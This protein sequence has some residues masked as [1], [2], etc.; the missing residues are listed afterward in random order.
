M[1]DFI[2]ETFKARDGAK[3]FYRKSSED[4][5]NRILVLHGLLEYSV[6]YPP[7]LDHLFPEG[8]VSWVV[9]DLRGH[10]VSEG[11]RNE[12]RPEILSND[13]EDLLAHIGWK[14]GTFSG[15]AHSFGGLLALYI[16]CKKPEFFKSL[17]LSAPFLGMPD[18]KTIFEIWF[19]LLLASLFPNKRYKNPVPAKYLTHNPER[20]ERYKND[21]LI[22]HSI[23]F[24]SLKGIARMQSEVTQYCNIRV[25]LLM[26]IAGD[27]RIVSKRAQLQWFYK[28]INHKKNKKEFEGFYHEVFNEPDNEAV[29]EQ[30]RKFFTKIFEGSEDRG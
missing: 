8:G 1:T 7:I 20:I 30:A 24:S 3:L 19:F 14:E 9:P 25:P 13:I 27:E 22:E 5:P 16:T 15:L 4:S 2:E 21:A 17:L 12:I 29:Y 6:S 28:C 10:G 18:N 23:S 11:L 26:F